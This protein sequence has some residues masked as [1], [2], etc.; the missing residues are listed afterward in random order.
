VATR[1]VSP[2]LVGR[3]DQ[4]SALDAA[5]A[6]ARNSNP[7]AMLIGGEAGIGKSRLVIEF[8]ERARR[9]GAQVL[10]GSCLE[11]GADGL[12]FAPFTSVLRQLV[13]DLGAD[14]VAELLPSGATRELARLL[15]EFGEPA[16]SVD[17]G[18]ARARLFEQMLILLERLAERGPLVLVVEDAHWADRSTR[19]MLAFLIRNQ[20]TLDGLL[21]VVSYRSDELHRTHPLRPMLAELDRVGWVARLEL[22]RLTRRDTDNLVVGITASQ[23]PDHVLADVYHRTEGNPLSLRH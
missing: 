23:P 18:T 12:P 11:L 8:A 10:T 19:D 6:E 9:A 3:A 16:A 15:P 14:G 4:L 13:R 22:H 21:I 20:H 5:L 7:S 1:V 17:A 2:I